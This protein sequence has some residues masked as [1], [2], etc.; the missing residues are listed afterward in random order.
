MTERPIL[1]R[2][3]LLEGLDESGNAQVRI[4][5]AQDEEGHHSPTRYVDPGAILELAAVFKVRDAL[6]AL[7]EAVDPENPAHVAA[8]GEFTTLMEAAS[9]DFAR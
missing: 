6:C 5:Y 9:G 8:L 1:I 2:A 4:P 3:H 7:F